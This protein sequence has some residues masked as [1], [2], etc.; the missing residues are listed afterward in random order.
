MFHY[1]T[2]LNHKNFTQKEDKDNL[3]REET[4]KEEENTK[5]ST[6]QWHHF[7]SKE[8]VSPGGKEAQCQK[9]MPSALN[10]HQ[11]MKLALNKISKWWRE[12]K[13]KKIEK[14]EKEKEKVVQLEKW[15]IIKE[16]TKPNLENESTK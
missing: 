7:M 13:I 6:L 9:D 15:N 4:V 3:D 11:F 16:G 12:K 8:N 5:Y 2:K 10:W 1:N 14:K